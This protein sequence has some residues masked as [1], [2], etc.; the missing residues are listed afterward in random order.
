[1]NSSEPELI[2]NNFPPEK[3]KTTA[4]FLQIVLENKRL[5]DVRAPIEF[6]KGAFNNSVNLPLMDDSER[7]KV[8]ICYKNHG[9]AEAVKLGHELIRG[10]IKS[11]KIQ[12]WKKELEENPDAFLYCFRGGLRSRISQQWILD[13]TGREIPRLEGGY[14]AFRRFLIDSLESISAELTTI[15]LGGRT[16]SGKTIFLKQF[17]NFVDLEGHANHRG[18]SFGRLIVPQPSQISFENNLAYDLIIKK[19]LGY[20]P[21]VVEDEG[22]NIGRCHIPETIFNNLTGGELVIIEV[23]FEERV[24]LI[25]EEYVSQAQS[26]YDE[27]KKLKS[28]IPDW[29]DT[30]NASIDRIKKRLGGEKYKRVKQLLENAWLKQQESGELEKHKDWVRVL[31]QEYYDPMYDYQIQKR[32]NR[33]AFR[34][35]AD[36]V[37]EYIKSKSK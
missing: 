30:V 11:A 3:L 8:G 23:P 24:D 12:A 19:S 26:E 13:E 22:R 4:D 6:K 28:D 17:E 16:G 9:N 27:A 37:L 15:V 31:L 35:N 33:V 20:N 5:I 32:E 21:L 34:G 25:F 36:E 7:H 18:S 29:I 10:K 1:M 14:K 2:D